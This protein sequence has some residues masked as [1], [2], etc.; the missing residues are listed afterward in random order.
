MPS[1]SGVIAIDNIVIGAGQA[2][3]AAAYYLQQHR[4]PFIVLEAADTAG[5]AWT[6]RYDSLRLF[7]PVWASGLPGRPW[8]GSPW[9]YPTT[10]EAAAYL[11]AYAAHFAF[12]VVFGRRVT[13]LRPLADGSFQLETAV[14]ATYRARRV[15]V[16]TGPYMAPRL[17][18]FASN[19][20]T[21]PLQ[22]H[23]SQYQRP[24]QVPGRGAV[25]VV[26]SGNSALQIAADLAVSGRPVYIA[27]DERVKPFANNHLGWLIMVLTGLL[28][29][30]GHSR[31]GRWLRRQPETVVSRDFIHL[32]RL[33]NVQ[34]V[35]RAIAAQPDGCLQGQLATTPPLEA[36]VW[37]TGFRPAYDWLE[38][39]IFDT[40]G[41]PRHHRGLTAVPGLAFLG[42]PWLDNRG[43]ALLYGAGRDA[44][45][46]VRT[47]LQQP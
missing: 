4:A 14:G 25:A 46:V 15:L 43:S 35:G 37:A 19:L 34:F 9:H 10:L 31:L 36:V 33:T 22:L 24:S 39:P 12:P 1:V 40:D 17:P 45:R 30:P 16:A 7:S 42:L 27:F 44:R 3:L 23:S 29:A 11:Q 18:A 21:N 5:S 41:R 47:L 38:A 26:G 28:R 8:P 32:R 6:A 2:G 13:R 20:P